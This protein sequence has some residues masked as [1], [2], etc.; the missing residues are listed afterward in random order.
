[1]LVVQDV[2]DRLAVKR[3]NG[4]HVGA[5]KLKERLEEH[6]RISLVDDHLE[7]ITLLLAV[8][9]TFEEQEFS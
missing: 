9:Q 4:G 2:S 3:E 6:R 5:I 8:K 7:Y 1:M